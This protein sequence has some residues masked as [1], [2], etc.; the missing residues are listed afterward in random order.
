[1]CLTDLSE[2][3]QLV[4]NEMLISWRNDS[5]PIGAIIFDKNWGVVARGRNSIHNCAKSQPISCHELAHAEINAMWQVSKFRHENIE[6]YSLLTSLEPC[7]LCFGA[8]VMSRIANLEFGARDEFAGATTALDAHGYTK[9]RFK[10]IKGP[11]GEFER[12]Q[13]TLLAEFIGRR[14]PHDIPRILP[15]WR[16]TSPVA[17]K[18][19]IDFAHDESLFLLA[20]KLTDEEIWEHVHQRLDAA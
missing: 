18:V 1:M 12:F 9:G 7:M 14:L 3:W 2:P 10:Q 19:G 13:L 11:S 15:S 4:T 6:S 16:E 20:E 8:F 17:V 5:F